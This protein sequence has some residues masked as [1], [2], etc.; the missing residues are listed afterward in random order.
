MPVAGKAG[1]RMNSNLRA[2]LLSM[3]LFASTVVLFWRTCSHGFLNWDDPQYVQMNREVLTGV[4]RANAAWA[5]TTFN[6]A[7]W[8]PL[9]WLSLQLDTQF[10]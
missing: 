6:A 4:T 2:I 8:H 7:N 5:F 3:A 1:L 10:F 9:T